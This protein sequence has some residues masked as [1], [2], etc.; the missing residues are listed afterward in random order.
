MKSDNEE[1]VFLNPIPISVKQDE[2]VIPENRYEDIENGEKF[3]K[4]FKP[5][6]K[7]TYNRAP[8]SDER[9][10]KD[11]YSNIGSIDLS[12]LNQSS[13]MNTQFHPSLTQR[14]Y[15]KDATSTQN[16][17]GGL[18]HYDANPLLVRKKNKYQ[19]KMVGLRSHWLGKLLG[20]ED[21]FDPSLYRSTF[22]EFFA[23]IIFTFI[24]GLIWAN[25]VEKPFSLYGELSDDKD[26]SE[27]KYKDPFIVISITHTILLTLFIFIF[28]PSSGAHINPL[29][30]W[31]TACCGFTSIPRTIF[32]TIAQFVGCAIGSVLVAYTISQDVIDSI[33]VGNCELGPDMNVKQGL[34]IE[35]FFCLANIITIFG[36][37]FTADQRQIFG[38]VLTPPIIASILGLL[39]WCSSG[40]AKGYTGAGM[41]PAMCFGTSFATN[42]RGWNDFLYV[43]LPGAL[44]AAILHAPF[45]LIIPPNH[46]EIYN[47]YDMETSLKLAQDTNSI[48]SFG[49][50]DDAIRDSNDTKITN[51]EYNLLRN[52]QEELISSPTSNTKDVY[53]PFCLANSTYRYGA[54]HPLRTP[55]VNIATLPIILTPSVNQ[56]DV[57]WNGDPSLQLMQNIPRNPI[58]EQSCGNLKSGNV[59]TAFYNN[60]DRVTRQNLKKGVSFLMENM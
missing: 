19:R 48:N 35:I 10:A 23:M 11:F 53:N 37:A 55:Q 58:M 22:V 44:I 9:Y 18:I 14:N 20:I 51:G 32:Y 24:R 17:R 57:F 54:C 47:N 25:A 7:S 42:W 2:N 46:D 31:A 45:F 28:A 30:T 43:F 21:L 38:D 34:I 59:E 33:G 36:T 4:T 41:N 15:K 3:T 29:V 40:L 13:F 56:N 12:K 49:A 8:S 1:S 26:K 27:L 6:L 52:P 60:A 5:N 16:F 39:T 50:K